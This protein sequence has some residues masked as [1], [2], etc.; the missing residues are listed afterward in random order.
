MNV[1]AACLRRALRDPTRLLSLSLAEWDLLVRQARRAGILARLAIRLDEAGLLDAVPEAP[2]RHLVGER[3][4][5]EKHRRDVRNEVRYIA[6][7]LSPTGVPVILLKGAAYILAELPPASGRLFSDIDILVPKTSLATV[8]QALHRQGWAGGRMAPYDE[9]YYR[10]WMHQIPPLTNR[11]RDTTLDV[12]H[13][14]IPETVRIDLRAGALFAA[15]R[16]VAGDSRVMTLAPTDM[17]LHSAIHLLNEGEY[18]RGLRDL[19]DVTELLGHFGQEVAFWQRLLDRAVELDLRRPLYYAL[20]YAAALLDAPV[21]AAIRGSPQLR[22]PGGAL[23]TVMD[24]LFERAFRPDHA[25]CRDGLSGTALWLLYVRSHHL[26]MPAHL[27]IPHLL[28]KAY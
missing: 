10:R 23:R 28:R 19:D 4:L 27:L 7:A 18:A 14:I 12:H 15:A 11:L 16:A 6:E 5:A 20:R 26:R 1:S 9:R 21:P 13:T 8:E 2:R 25:S 24:A 22:P 3:L 17:I